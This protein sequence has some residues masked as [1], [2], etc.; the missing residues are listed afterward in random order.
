MPEQPTAHA[1]GSRHNGGGAS[2]THVE[3]GQAATLGR[4]AI[5]ANGAARRP[6]AIEGESR[7]VPAD[8]VPVADI[9][10][11]QREVR[12][13]DIKKDQL[14]HRDEKI[15]HVF[16]HRR[17]FAIYL[18]GDKVMVHYADNEKTQKRQTAAV[19]EL[20]FLRGRLQFLM[21]GIIKRPNPYH[22]QI[23]EALRL[24]LDGRKA[25]SKAML[26]MLIDTI[27][28]H[29]LQEGCDFYLKWTAAVVLTII[30]ALSAAAAGHV[31]QPDEIA[32]GLRCLMLATGSGAIGAA[33]S[34]ALALQARN[35]SAAVKA[36]V[37]P[38]RN[39]IDGAARI[40][41]G[42]ASAAALYLFLDSDFLSAIKIGDLAIKPDIDWKKALMVGFMGGFLERLV[43]DLLEK[44]FAVVTNKLETNGDGSRRGSS[45]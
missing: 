28:E 8:R 25:E 21:S 18:S 22:C 26:Q 2:I 33:M 14:D 36:H 4:P 7:N 5:A 37:D 30:G 17:N 24:C 19:A 1:T 12:V 42:V 31:D 13:A 11:D 41:I 23:A 3:N 38:K 45:A 16:Y 10:K 34:T 20:V 40:L 44:K 43:P 39:A 15:E 9:K 29:R 27:I 6:R 35:G 32:A